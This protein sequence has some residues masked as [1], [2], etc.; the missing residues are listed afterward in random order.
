[1]KTIEYS[2]PGLLAIVNTLTDDQ[3]RFSLATRPQRV[4][5]PVNVL[6]LGPEVNHRGWMT[7][8]QSPPLQ[9]VSET[10]RSRPRHQNASVIPQVHQVNGLICVQATAIVRSGTLGDRWHLIRKSLGVAEAAIG[11]TSTRAL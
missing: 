11:R 4:A 10:A 7:L 2:R 9:S 6:P 3:G 5:A 1:M 8:R